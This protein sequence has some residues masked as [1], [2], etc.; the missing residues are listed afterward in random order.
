MFFF[1]YKAVGKFGL[2]KNALFW[3]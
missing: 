2:K 1:Q 3:S